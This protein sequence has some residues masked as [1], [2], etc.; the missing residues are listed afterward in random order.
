[1]PGPNHATRERTMLDNTI[2]RLSVDHPNGFIIEMPRDR[3]IY[4]ASTMTLASE[5]RIQYQAGRVNVVLTS[6]FEE[7]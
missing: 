5:L 2:R 7:V 3:R 6:L 1:M 4:C